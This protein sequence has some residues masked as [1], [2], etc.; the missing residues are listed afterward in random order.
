MVNFSL[1]KDLCN[2]Y[3][4]PIVSTSANLEA[5]PPARDEKELNKY[6]QTGIDFIVEGKTGGF[7]KASQIRDVL[8]GKIIRD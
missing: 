3:G 4:S 1:A 2:C 6:F 8:T 5:F 7:E